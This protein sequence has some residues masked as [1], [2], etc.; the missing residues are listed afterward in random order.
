MSNQNLKANVII[1]MLKEQE[2]VLT[3]DIQRKNELKNDLDSLEV[4][5]EIKQQTIDK[6]KE[7]LADLGQEYYTNNNQ[8]LDNLELSSSLPSFDNNWSLSTPFTLKI[9]ESYQT[10]NGIDV[11]T[12][13][14]KYGEQGIKCHARQI[15]EHLNKLSSDNRIYQTNPEQQR[16]RK[17]H[18]VKLNLE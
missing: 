15:F 2:T 10:P 17:Y 4:E 16:G 7:S 11:K 3:Q 8:K 1:K 5:I 6:L 13:I 14:N 12:I 18:T 9:I